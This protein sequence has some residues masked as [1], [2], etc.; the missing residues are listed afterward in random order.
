MDLPP[1]KRICT[2]DKYIS[3]E[4]RISRLSS[5]ST[6]QILPS[7]LWHEIFSYFDCEELV[8]S[9]YYSS[10][11]FQTL[12]CND[13]VQIHLNI[14]LIRSSFSI[15]PPV[16]PTQI[17]SLRIDY[18]GFNTFDTLHT[19][20]F[21]R[22]RSLHLI[23]VNNEELKGISRL[24][25]PNLYYICIESGLT[26]YISTIIC[27]YF[28]RVVQMKL[29][30]MGR[31]FIVEDPIDQKELSQVKYLV[32]D[33]K[34]EVISFH[35]LYRLIKHV[36]SI[37]IINYGL[38]DD[39]YTLPEDKIVHNQLNC[40]HSLRIKITDTFFR[41]YNLK[42]LVQPTLEYLSIIGKMD[43]MNFRD[44]TL[45]SNWIQLKHQTGIRLK[46]IF[47]NISTIYYDKDE[48]T[49]SQVIINQCSDNIFKNIKIKCEDFVIFLKGF[50]E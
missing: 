2:D 15:F 16:R 38:F 24:Q 10:L 6:Y 19:S 21:N 12:L 40:L 44:Y 42:I 39:N 27:V 50:I 18:R 43:F 1:T 35:H 23:F 8:Y 11:F 34:L 28:P 47:L 45:S 9:F 29:N 17:I 49:N 14:P 33:G 3:T 32:L 36:R 48:D 37:S 5:N 26:R 22:L 31:E 30:S 7:E 46:K 4:T 25:L 13:N 41:F 20:H